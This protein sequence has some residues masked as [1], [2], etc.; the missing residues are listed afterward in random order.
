MNFFA[1][2][3]KLNLSAE[4]TFKV[5]QTGDTFQVIVFIS[6]QDNIDKA[7][8]HIPP[9][10]LSG[11]AEELDN[12]L[13]NAISEPLT[14]VDT[15]LLNM[16]SFTKSVERAKEE[17]AIV[18]ASKAA[19]AENKKQWDALH[20]KIKELTA[21]ADYEQAY[22]LLPNPDKFPS[23]AE[24]IQKLKQELEFKKNTLTLF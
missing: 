19:E 2:L 23:N 10:V 12:G 6:N 1:Q 13:I 20:N 7:A 16:V 4:C 17:S 24:D 3:Q 11:T 14:V 5:T 15:L 18:K 22:A 9:L 21:N 8:H